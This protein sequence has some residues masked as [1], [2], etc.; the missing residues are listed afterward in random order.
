MKKFATAFLIISLA[1][2]TQGQNGWSWPKDEANYKTA[3]E[4]QAYYKL[5]MSQGKFQDALET[6]QWLYDNNA[7]LNP[8]IY[9][10]GVK[11]VEE[12]MESSDDKQLQSTMKDKAL[13]MYDQ[14]IKYWNQEASVLDRQAYAAFKYYYKTPAKY[15][16]I[17]DLYQKAFEKN[18]ADISDFNLV[19]YMTAAK[20]GYE[21]KVSGVDADFVLNIHST[22]TE[23]MNEKETAGKDMKD[24]RDK[25]DAIFSSLE[26]VLTCGYIKENLVRRLKEN[27]GDLNTAKKIVA[28]SITAKCTN[29]AYFLE[30]GE[31]VLKKE[32]SF[33]F[34]KIIADKRLARDEVSKALGLYDKALP[35][36][37]T[38]QDRYDILMTQA[39]IA[40]KQDQKEKAR[41]LALKASAEKPGEKE[42]FNLIGNLYFSSYKE[43]AGYK[44]KVK[45]R[46][47]FIAAYNMYEKAGNSGQMSACKEQFPS[48]EEIFSEN[49]KEGQEMNTGCWVNETVKIQRRS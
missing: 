45:D 8:S 6:L 11:C 31:A 35:L 21:R 46:L 43:C 20:Y 30:A 38:A 48:V 25:V 42:P 22:I 14:R 34:Y 26:T 28:Y 32:P 29:E 33:K 16:V 37:K 3:Q 19:P 12:L 41:E 10:D 15:A 36:A 7:E 9:I 23:V 49:L 13:W 44:S 4:K 24:Y 5:Q 47:V 17:F 40:S 39:K 2:Q 18:G 1:I 27:P